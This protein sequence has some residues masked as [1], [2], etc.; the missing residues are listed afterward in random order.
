MVRDALET[1]YDDARSAQELIRRAGA[2]NPV[3]LLAAALSVARERSLQ[4]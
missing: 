4:R 3:A 2:S 1:S